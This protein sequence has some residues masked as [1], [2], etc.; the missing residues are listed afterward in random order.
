MASSDAQPQPSELSAV[1][2]FKHASIG[3]EQSEGLPYWI[4]QVL[5]RVSRK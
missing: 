2:H 5:P 1:E 4:W 3:I